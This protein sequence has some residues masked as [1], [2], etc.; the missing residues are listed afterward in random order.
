MEQTSKKH[1]LLI[2][3]R[4]DLGGGPKHLYELTKGLDKNLFKISVAAPKQK[5]FGDLL[6]NSSSHFLSLP[7]R[8][9]SLYRF[10][11]IL[12]FCKNLNVSIIHSHGRGAGL[13]SRLF[14]LFGFKVVHTFHGVHNE[15]SIMG[16]IKLSIDK[17]LAPLTDRFISVSP[18][19][20]VKSF[21]LRVSTLENTQV[22]LNGVPINSINAEFESYSKQQ[23]REKFSLPV[24]KEIWGTLARLSYIKGID[25]LLDMP[26][27]QDKLFVIAG[28]GEDRELLLEK[29]KSS[30]N[31]NIVFLGPTLN[32]A[33]FLRSL[34]GYFSTSRGEGLP[35]SVLEA[36][37]VGLPCLLSDVEGH[38]NLSQGATLFDLKS[39]TD[40]L[41]KVHSIDK[42]SSA[43]KAKEFVKEGYCVR[44]M[45]SQIEE[46]YHSL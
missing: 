14:G 12:V 36:M 19:E 10:F 3:A 18:E 6:L 27:P 5:P 11:R 17:L 25:L 30:K 1:I 2:S 8:F 13:Y 34:D 46:L 4:S 15:K 21:N 16:Q 44:R 33:I 41:D 35:L 32:P 7:H 29:M 31:K 37:A 45:V 39:P 24:E 26:L 42:L 22:I 40:F 28:D 20:S 23:A 43:E 38:Q 9:F